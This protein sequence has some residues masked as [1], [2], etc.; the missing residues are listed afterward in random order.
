[1]SLLLGGLQIGCAPTKLYSGE[2][3]PR[4]Q[5]AVVK[6][7]WGSLVQVDDSKYIT[8]G[9]VLPGCHVV[10]VAP[11]ETF[12]PPN[13]S[14]FNMGGSRKTPGWPF[15]SVILEAG[16]VYNTS[17]VETPSFRCVLLDE[18]TGGPPQRV[19]HCK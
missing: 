1:M 10:A 5:V 12:V 17:C 14:N 15:G 6:A 9:E 7:G 13:P 18:A 8:G 3:L 19:A 11:G 16:H 4:D 2:A